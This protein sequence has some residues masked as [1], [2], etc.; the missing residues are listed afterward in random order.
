[1]KKWHSIKKEGPPKKDK[2]YIIFVETADENKPY[3]NTAWYSPGGFGWS[4]LPKCF[5][6]SITHYMDMPEW[7]LERNI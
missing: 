3:I 4:L 1:M 7:P 5:I 6:S 2:L